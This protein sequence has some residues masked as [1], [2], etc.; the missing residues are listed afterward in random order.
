MLQKKKQEQMDHMSMEKSLKIGKKKEHVKN[1]WKCHLK[2]QLI[3]TKSNGKT[4][5]N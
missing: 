2:M 3:I 4:L 1:I 5:R